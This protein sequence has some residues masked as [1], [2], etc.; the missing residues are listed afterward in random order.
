MTRRELEFGIPELVRTAESV[1]ALPKASGR[2]LFRDRAQ[3]RAPEMHS[4]A[5]VG[6]DLGDLLLEL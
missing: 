6:A 3:Q 2:E 5:W 4:D 1:I